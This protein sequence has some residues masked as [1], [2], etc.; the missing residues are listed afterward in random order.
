[1]VLNEKLAFLRKEKRLTQLQVAEK[2]N[3]SRQAVSGWETGTMVPSTDNLKCLSLLYKVPVDCLLHEDRDLSARENPVDNNQSRSH[4][5]SIYI[6]VFATAA[7]LIIAI[8]VVLFRQF[9][10]K[11]DKE[12]TNLE[13]TENDKWNESQTEIELG[14]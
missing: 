7:I 9:H 12:T 2:V 8:V 1:M 14:F 6:C 13:S 4:K 3:V 11:G 10:Y 5:K